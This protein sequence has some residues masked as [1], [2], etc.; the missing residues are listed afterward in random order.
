MWVFFLNRNSAKSMKLDEI[1]M[2]SAK[3][4]VAGCVNT[5]IWTRY[6]QY[7]WCQQVMRWQPLWASSLK[8]PPN[9]PK[10]TFKKQLSSKSP[11]LLGNYISL[12][13]LENFVENPPSSCVL[14]RFFVWKRNP[15][16]TSSL[17][18]CTGALCWPSRAS[19]GWNGAHPTWPMNG[20][21]SQGV[22]RSQTVTTW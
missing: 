3:Q 4:L 16:W 22:L 18:C 15:C 8:K 9:D 5:A 19:L 14:C 20:L 11:K 17:N 12:D 13:F 10:L 6:R 1:P 21:L 2:I 7:D